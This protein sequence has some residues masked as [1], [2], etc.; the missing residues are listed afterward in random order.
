MILTSYEDKNYN[1][2]ISYIYFAAIYYDISES[3]KSVLVVKFSEG[4]VK[5][6]PRN[7]LFTNDCCIKSIAGTCK[8]CDGGSVAYYDAKGFYKN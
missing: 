6:K 2:I 4:F 5:Y 3:I 1:F 8:Q 7:P